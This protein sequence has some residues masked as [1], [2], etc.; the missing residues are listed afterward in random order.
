[1]VLYIQ[2]RKYELLIELA[3]N[4]SMEKFLMGCMFFIV[5]MFHVVL[6]LAIYL[7]VTIQKIT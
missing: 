7:L 1:M 6:T 5:V 2:Q 4:C 3:M